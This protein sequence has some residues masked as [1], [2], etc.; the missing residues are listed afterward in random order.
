MKRLN[1]PADGLLVDHFLG[2]YNLSMNKLA[3]VGIYRISKL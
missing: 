1:G 3:H 2:L